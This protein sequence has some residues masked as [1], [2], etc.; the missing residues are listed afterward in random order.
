MIAEQL[1]GDAA[2][3]LLA[4]FDGHRG[5][6]AAEYAAAHVLPYLQRSWAAADPAAALSRTFIDLDA[7]YRQAE[8]AEYAA[9]VQRVGE[10]SA[11][12]PPPDGAAA[13]WLSTHTF[14]PPPLIN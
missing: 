6:A 7:D 11:G 2:T 10:G 5:A 8:A 9:R 12:T 3:T 13:P 4:V 14:C 1:G